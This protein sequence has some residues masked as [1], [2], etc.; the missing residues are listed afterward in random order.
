MLL[1]NF[2]RFLAVILVSFTY[3]LFRY[4]KSFRSPP[5]LSVFC[6]TSLRSQLTI[7][8]SDHTNSDTWDGIKCTRSSFTRFVSALFS[9]VC[10]SFSQGAETWQPYTICYYDFSL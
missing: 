10:P 5:P 9:E 3:V 2:N 1:R 6:D 8:I 4:G 7:A